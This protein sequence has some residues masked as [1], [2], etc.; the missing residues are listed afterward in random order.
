MVPASPMLRSARFTTAPMPI[1]RF[2]WDDPTRSLKHLPL[3]KEEDGWH[4]LQQGFD[5]GDAT[6]YFEDK[7]AVLVIGGYVLIP[8]D[9]TFHAGRQPLS[10]HPATLSGRGL[11]YTTNGSY[12]DMWEWH[13]ANGGP[14]GWMDD[15]HFGPPTDPT[16]AQKQ[17]TSAYKGG[18]AP[19][20]GSANSALNFEERGPGGYAQPITPKRLPR[21]IRKVGLTADRIDLDPD[22]SDSD[23]TNWWMSDVDSAPY[24]KE[25]DARIPVGTIIP[26]VLVTDSYSGD[27]ADIRCAAKWAAG[28]WTLEVVR[29]L[30]TGSKYDAAIATGSYMRVSVFDHAQSRHTRHIRPIRLE[31]NR[32]EKP[33]ECTST[34]KNSRPSVARSS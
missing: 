2:V 4:V 27:R 9:R 1:S 11:H 19:D 14:Q 8:G 24:T 17:G 12:V 10:D 13:A 22:H 33:A 16:D 18:F 20:P 34:S 29:R 26:G 21:D 15:A 25:R 3:R 28:R 31:V 30:D 7:L 6:A 5:R 32:C 23:E